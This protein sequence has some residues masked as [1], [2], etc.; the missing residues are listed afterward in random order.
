MCAIPQLVSAPLNLQPKASADILRT[1]LKDL[2]QKI[3]T[4][5]QPV[6]VSH[7]IEQATGCEPTMPCLP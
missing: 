5:V 2:S 7:K 4:T 6:F 3:H 1:Q